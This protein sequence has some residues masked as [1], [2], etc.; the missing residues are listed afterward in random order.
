MTMEDI[1]PIEMKDFLAS[2]KTI[3]PSVSKHGIEKFE[4]WA[5]EFGERGG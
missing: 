4:E 5:R 1:R 3:R 2:L